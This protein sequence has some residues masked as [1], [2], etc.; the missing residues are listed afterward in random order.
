MV[1]KIL[2]PVDGSAPSKKALEF[3][4]EIAG[5]FEATIS[6][7]HVVSDAAAERHVM[8]LGAAHTTTPANPEK[9]E[10]AG[11]P[12]IDAATEIVESKG[13]KLASADAVAGG[14]AQAILESAEQHGID[15]IVMGSRGLSD[16]AGL[17]MGSTSH[18]VSNLAKCTCIV[19]R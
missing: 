3:A 10:E 15:T 12:V 9:V 2:V 19:V 6:V 18:K 5:R 11:K 7:I 17:L 1:E 14:P 13:V 8:V 16:I 4:C